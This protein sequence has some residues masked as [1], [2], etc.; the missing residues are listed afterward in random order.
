MTPYD[1]LAGWRLASVDGPPYADG[2]FPGAMR[3]PGLLRRTATKEPETL[4]VLPKSMGLM[5]ELNRVLLLGSSCVPS[6]HAGLRR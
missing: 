5:L 1:W 2:R 3:T 6:R 4:R